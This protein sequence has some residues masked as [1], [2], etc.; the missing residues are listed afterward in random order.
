M[1]IIYNIIYLHGFSHGW[2]LPLQH[3][4]EFDRH[5]QASVLDIGK[6]PFALLAVIAAKA[7]A[8]KVY[9]IEKTLGR[10]VGWGR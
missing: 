7:G 8:K 5:G 4:A 2:F 3:S 10:E 9:A 6:G 1:Y